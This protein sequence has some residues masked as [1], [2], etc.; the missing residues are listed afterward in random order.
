M[1]EG[2]RTYIGPGTQRS[3]VSHAARAALCIVSPSQP[4]ASSARRTSAP[5]FPGPSAAIL[6]GST[7]GGPSG[8]LSFDMVL[9][10]RTNSVGVAL[11]HPADLMESIGVSEPSFLIDWDHLNTSFGSRPG[12][13]SSASVEAPAR[14]TLADS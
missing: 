14:V 10:F 5:V 1:G 4:S 3:N 12:T 7:V 2:L 9:P 8:T 11:R 6:T 13:G